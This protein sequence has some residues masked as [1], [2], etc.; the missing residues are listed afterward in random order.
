MVIKTLQWNIGGGKI[1]TPSS[2][3]ELEQSYSIDG[4]AE[5]AQLAKKYDPDIVTLQ[6]THANDNFVQVD[7]LAKDLGLPYFFP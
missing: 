7:K 4:L 1:R 6:E 2:N 3:P 5:I